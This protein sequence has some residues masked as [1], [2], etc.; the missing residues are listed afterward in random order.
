MSFPIARLFVLCINL[1]IVSRGGDHLLS[2]K[3]DQFQDFLMR[4]WTIKK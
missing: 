2:L 1:G 4:K 3:E